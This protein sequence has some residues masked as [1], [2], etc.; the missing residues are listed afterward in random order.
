MGDMFLLG[1]WVF[2]LLIPVGLALIAASKLRL[3]R[4]D[5]GT[6]GLHRKVDP[7]RLH[8]LEIE[9]GLIPP[10]RP[11]GKRPVGPPPKPSDAARSARPAWASALD[12]G[13]VTPNEMRCNVCQVLATNP[14]LG[15]SRSREILRHGACK[16]C[17]ATRVHA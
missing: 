15:G 12:A 6:R 10:D 1:P 11:N 16:K 13:L 14:A 2:V 8:R 3:H 5:D 9:A 7:D 4:F 17:A